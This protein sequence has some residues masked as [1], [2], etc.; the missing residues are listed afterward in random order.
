[1][2]GVREVILVELNV[3]ELNNISAGSNV[4][5][6]FMAAAELL[7]Y[8][9]YTKQEVADALADRFD[10][11]NQVIANALESLAKKYAISESAKSMHN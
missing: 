9:G 3:D 2:Y 8:Q 4:V 1:M 10:F 5:G 6:E 7:F 11:S